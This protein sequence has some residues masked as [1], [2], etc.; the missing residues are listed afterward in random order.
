MPSIPEVCLARP[1]SRCA[2]VTLASS[3]AQNN[4]DKILCVCVSVCGGW[5]EGN[6]VQIIGPTKSLLTHQREY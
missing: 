4:A 3:A 5:G 6:R 2:Q 1:D